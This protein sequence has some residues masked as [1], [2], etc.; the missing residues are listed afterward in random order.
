MTHHK[1]AQNE[2]KN[3]KRKQA[4]LNEVKL[5]PTLKNHNSAFP[6]MTSQDVLVKLECPPHIY[7]PS[8]QRLVSSYIPVLYRVTGNIKHLCEGL[9]N[10]RNKR[11]SEVNMSFDE[12]KKSLISLSLSLGD[13]FKQ[14]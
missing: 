8:P 13:F 14:I 6:V 2:K 1:K 12:K 5:F 3:Y 10:G 7:V 9:N 4:Q 11:S